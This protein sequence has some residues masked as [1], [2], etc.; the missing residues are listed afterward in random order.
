MPAAHPIL[1]LQLWGE[2]WSSFSKWEPWEWIRL[3]AQ[4]GQGGLFP[5]L[6][7]STQLG[8]NGCLSGERRNTLSPLSWVGCHLSP[9][10]L[11]WWG[12][13][14]L[15][16]FVLQSL[17]MGGGWCPLSDLLRFHSH[18]CESQSLAASLF[19]FFFSWQVGTDAFCHLW[20]KNVNGHKSYF[21]NVFIYSVTD[22]NN[23]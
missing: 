4:S 23:T 2:M 17:V 7:S 19:F 6:I 1:F 18:W 14:N 11:G 22:I 3:W 16:A 9:S 8:L 10:F 15:T 12:L 21:Y 5:N 13:G 20:K